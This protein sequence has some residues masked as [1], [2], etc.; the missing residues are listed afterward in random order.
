MAV[1]TTLLLSITAVAAVTAAFTTPAWADDMRHSMAV[2]LSDLR[3]DRP[4][5]VAAGYERITYAANQVCGPR[6]TTG[7]YY[8]APGYTRCYTQAVDQAVASANRPELTAFHRAV[9]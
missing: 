7:S 4:S 5:D 6:A 8:T 9:K 2:S 1:K 3:F